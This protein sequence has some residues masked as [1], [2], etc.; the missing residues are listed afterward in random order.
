MGMIS[1]AGVA[2]AEGPVAW[3]AF[4]SAAEDTVADRAAGRQD[5]VEGNHKLI[6]GPVAG[7]LLFDGFT[8][9]ID[10][11]AAD[12]PRLSSDFSIEAWVAQG[13]Y[14]WNWCPIITQQR[15]NGRPLA[16]RAG[17]FEK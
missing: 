15:P 11:P 10:R 6:R 17:Q 8:T 12:A 2:R 13:A 3:W 1:T 4:D 14:P 7:A 5:R 16:L 9:V